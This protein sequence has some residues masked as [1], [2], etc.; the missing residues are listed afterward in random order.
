MLKYYLGRKEVSKADYA[1]AFIANAKDE[2]QT[3]ETALNVIAEDEITAT[4]DGFSKFIFA[5]CDEF[6]IIAS[7]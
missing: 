2:L 4:L 1:D 5:N 7:K 6:I 3:K